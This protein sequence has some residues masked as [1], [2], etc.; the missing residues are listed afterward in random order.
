MEP[1]LSDSLSAKTDYLFALYIPHCF[2]QVL[3]RTLGS[4][5]SPRHYVKN[6][7]YLLDQLREYLVADCANIADTLNI[8]IFWC[9]S[10]SK[11]KL[12]GV[13][14]NQWFRLAVVNVKTLTYC[15]C[16]IIGTLYQFF[17]GDIVFPVG[18]GWIEDHVV[19]PSRRRMNATTTHTLN[20]FAI[21]DI[22][23]DDIINVDARLFHR[24]RLRY[25]ARK[26]IQQKSLF[27]VLFFDAL[28][29]QIDDDIV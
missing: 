24:F 14:A 9:R 19:G 12:A 2:S 8:D 16:G 21:V 26:A 5:W 13:K 28:F 23:L 18:L 29:H 6:C 11:G 3:P 17:T 15:F 1:K 4:L 25:G 22:N 20:Y 10:R 27:A 7:A